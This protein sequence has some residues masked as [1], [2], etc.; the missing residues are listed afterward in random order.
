MPDKLKVLLADD[1]VMLRQG[2]VSIIE[3]FS[4]VQK[5]FEANNGKEVIDFFSKGGVVD[6]MILD[7]SMPVLY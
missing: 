4:M 2:L 3:S 6:I 5:V 7:I 1:H